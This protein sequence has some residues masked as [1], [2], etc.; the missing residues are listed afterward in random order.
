MDSLTGKAYAVTG[1]NS[2][3][4]LATAHELVRHGAQVAIFG[5]DKQTL[6]TT[7]RELGA[8]TLAVRGDVTRR[9]DLSRFFAE[10]AHQFDWLDG[11]FVNAGM[12]TF[13]PIDT[14]T[15]EQ[16][17]SLLAVNFTGAVHT[18]QQALPL[19]RNE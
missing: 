15:E 16:I 10:I 9:D 7:Q 2:G 17:T 14:V 13:A 4:G 18:I 19:L 11:V 6:A 8:T 3:I 12:A 1:G 5:R